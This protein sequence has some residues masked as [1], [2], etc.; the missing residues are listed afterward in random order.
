MRVWE[1]VIIACFK[2][3]LICFVLINNKQTIEKLD[4]LEKRLSPVQKAM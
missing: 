2:V 1:E 3:N 4:S